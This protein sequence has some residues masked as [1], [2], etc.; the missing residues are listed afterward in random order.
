MAT[1]FLALDTPLDSAGSDQLLARFDGEEGISRPYSFRLGFWSSNTNITANDL[2]GKEVTVTLSLEDGSPRYFHGIVRHLQAGELSGRTSRFYQIEMVPYFRLLTERSNSRIFEQKSAPD[3]IAGILSEHGIK[4]DKSGI[5]AAHV[6]REYCVQYRETDFN[7]VSRLMEEEGIFYFFQHQKSSHTMVLC[8]DATGYVNP[9]LDISYRSGT[10]TGGA[11][12]LSWD[13]EYDFIP[14]RWVQTDYNFE[15]PTASL[16]T[17][18]PSQLNG[19][20]YPTKFEMFDYPGLYAKAPDGNTLTKYR[21]EE[22]EAIFNT[23]RAATICRALQSGGVF[24]LTHDIATESGNSWVVASVRHNARDDTQ[25]NIAG[26]SAEGTEY[27]N[28]ILALPSSVVFRPPRVTPKPYIHGLQTAV[29]TGPNGEEI[30]TDKYG[31]IQ[32]TF[33]WDRQTTASCWMRVAHGIAGRGWGMQ[34]LPRVGHEVVVSFLEG[35]PDRP[36]VIG[37][38]YNGDNAPPFTLPANKTQSGYMT[39]SS[40]NGAAADTNILRFEDLKGSEEVYLEAQKDYNCL[41]NN[42]HTLTVSADQTIKIKNNRT[43]TVETGN[44]SVTVQQGNRSVTVSQGNDTHKIDQGNRTVTI[45]MGNDDLEIKMGNQTTK[46]SLGSASTEAMQ[47]IELKVGQNSITIDQMGVTIKGMTI[48]IEGQLQTSL[49]GTM[50]QINGE[51]M[52]QLQGGIT[53]IG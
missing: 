43:E 48:S 15:T 47:S 33:F 31:R 53:M 38:V 29:V 45:S 37:S 18:C 20:N 39:R 14:Q 3:I 34:Y 25:I 28:D 24:T 40:K 19:G 5:K 32:V 10:A 50:T 7:F 13:H 35:D 26:Q 16:D 23:V 27:S 6:T 17:N 8:D 52:L 41:V 11:T 1:R 12:V 30:Y 51:A 44:D 4:F 46:V 21:M 49:K 9:G 42:N 2:I 22:D 36:L